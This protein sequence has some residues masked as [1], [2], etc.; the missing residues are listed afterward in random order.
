M[1]NASL[2][3]VRN[4]MVPVF[5]AAAG[6]ASGERAVHRQEP[7]AGI[8]ITSSRHFTILRCH[9]SILLV[10]PSFFWSFHQSSCHSEERS[11]EESELP[12]SARRTQTPRFA[13]VDN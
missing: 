9:S 1:A 12:P 2:H 3:S 10:I 13:R 7:P 4:G 11:D 8:T 6:R 5:D